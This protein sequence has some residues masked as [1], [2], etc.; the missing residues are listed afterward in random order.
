V[1]ETRAPAYNLGESVMLHSSELDSMDMLVRRL[2]SIA[3]LSREER[4][5]LRSL[6]VRIRTLKAGQDIVHDGDQPT[7]CCLVVEGWAF[8]YKLVGAGQRQILSFHVPGDMPD[9]LS[10]HLHTMDHSLATLT[11]ATVAFISH[12]IVHDLIARHPNIGALL[13]RNTLVDGA[14]FRQWIVAIGRRPAFPRI[15]HLFCELYLKLEAVGLAEGH[16]CTLPLKQ[17]QLA[18]ALGISNVH[19]NRVLKD[20]RG[21]GLVTMKGSALNIHAWDKLV[22]IAEFDDAYLHLKKR[23]FG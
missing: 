22:Q 9:L 19:V 21:K 2:E 5:A 6:P 8:R 13:W 4:Q 11:E 16:Q 3:D 20:M 7:Q 1:D 14:I 17:G 15:A 10:L 12:D 23:N 18:D